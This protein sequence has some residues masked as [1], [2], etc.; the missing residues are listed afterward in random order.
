MPNKDILSKH[1]LKR[2][3]IDMAIYLFNLDVSDA[4]L[5]ET[6]FQR[7]E[8]RRADLLL[9]VKAPEQ[10][11]LHIEVQNDNHPQMPE[12]MLRYWLDI[13]N[14]H[15][16]LPIHQYVV[17]IGKEKLRMLNAIQQT[18]LSYEY[19]LVDMR[20]IDCQHF[21]QHDSPDALVLAILCDFKERDSRLVVRHI[22]QRLQ[23]LLKDNESGLREYFGMLEILSGN[24]Q[25]ETIVNEEEKMLSAIQLSDLPSYKEGMEKGLLRLL[26]RQLNKKFGELSLDVEQR[27][28]NASDKQ[29][30]QWA[31][32]ILEA[33]N[34]EQV[35]L[36]S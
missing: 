25:L 23:A 4:E 5:L 13:H 22:V 28:E 2:I 11:L 33:E 18:C 20:E 19:K 21:L 29:L 31:D 24:R 34:L 9:F 35:F 36:E 15:P 1:L 10:F 26:K 30:E 14:T 8:D 7:V 3:A 6:E 12:R 32:N 17:Y 16:N 27:L